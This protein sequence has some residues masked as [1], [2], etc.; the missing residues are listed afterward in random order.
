MKTLRL[1][2]VPALAGVA[3]SVWMSLAD[4][5]TVISKER[6][7]LPTNMMQA[8]P[9]AERVPGEPADPDPSTW[10]MDA[11][12]GVFRHPGA[13][14]ETSG[15][16][17]FKGSLNYL[18]LNQYAKNTKVE[19]F[20]PVLVS[21]GHTWQTI[22]DLDGHRYMYDYYRDH[23]QVYDITDPR[24]LT[25]VGERRFDTKNGDHPF[26]PFN[27][28]YNRKLEKL[29]AV[30]CYETPRFGIL[31]NKYAQPEKEKI[32]RE[33]KFLR[34]FRVFEVVTPTEWKML[35][36]VTLD[37]HANAQQ[38]PQQGS[39]C[40]DVPFYIGD[41]FVFV[42]GAPD[43]TYSLQEYKSYLYSAAQLAYDISDPYHPKLMSVWSVP[44]QRIGEEAAYRENPRHGNKTSW[45]GARMPLFIPRPVEQGGK[46][47]YAAMGGLGFYVVDISD[48]AN[49]KTVGH[50]DL[51]VSVAGNEGDNIDVTKAE[52][53]GMVYF[54]GYPMSDDCYEPYKDI[55]QIDVRDPAHPKITGVLPRPTPPKEAG[56]TDYCERRAS[57]GPKRSGYLNQPGTP[58]KQYI[59][60]SFYNAGLQ[61]FDVSNPAHPFIA[62]YFVPKMADPK[63]STNSGLFRTAGYGNPTHGIFVEWDRH[64]IW[65]F[66]NH[67]VYAI[68]SPLLGTPVFG[69][70]KSGSS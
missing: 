5:Q 51:P 41:K 3:L 36:E 59:P 20:Y 26:G 21:S 8:P 33:M 4:G 6:P 54:S 32:I 64:L 30:Q 45:M 11:T 58:S 50:L 55:Y 31:K 35:S 53:T 66:T 9:P 44:G 27:I 19:A 38:M 60:Y 14:P 23:F 68:S 15:P 65:V 57:F 43:D 24:K 16:H 17:P 49:M 48:P 46:Y 22:F 61:I 13:T 1:Q 10:G 69:L 40:L 63:T 29:I 34:G 37:P 12:T 42:A 2:A 18:D 47:G 70:P 25:M 56:F 28:Q 67:G 7:P 39:G 62:A 52:I